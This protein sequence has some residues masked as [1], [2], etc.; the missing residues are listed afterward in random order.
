V[1]S[2]PARLVKTLTLP[3]VP[4]VFAAPARSQERPAVVKVSDR[5]RETSG[6]VVITGLPA[7]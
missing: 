6:S 2:L 4:L 1:T 7:F 5:F 3:F